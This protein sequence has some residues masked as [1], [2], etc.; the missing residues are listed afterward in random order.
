MPLPKLSPDDARA[1]RD[2]HVTFLLARLGS[3][4]A[5]AELAEG[6]RDGW[7]HVRAQRLD[8]L[9]LAKAA[10]Q[11]VE[12]LVAV[13]S[14]DALAS[15]W[16][17]LGRD[18]HARVRRDLRADGTKLGAW[19]PD[20]A[21]AA[22]DALLA[23]P[24]L[25]PPSL[26][27]TI[28]DQEGV[29]EVLRDVLYDALVEFNTT[30][31]PFFAEWGLPGLIKRFVPI[32]GGA[33]VK[34]IGALREE[35]DKRLEPEMRKFLLVFSR[36]AKKKVGAFLVAH[37]GDPSMVALRRNVAA[38]LYEQTPKALFA[39]YDDEAAAHVDR[40]AEA[41]AAAVVRSD[42]ARARL[43][44]SVAE[45]LRE[46]GE[47]TVGA[48]LDAVGATGAPDFDALAA[49]AWPSVELVLASPPFR[50]WLE[51]VTDDFYATLA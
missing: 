28:F 34:S 4:A 29:E 46:H 44:R 12:A 32:G 7:A 41:V 2:A 25:V 51:R 10:P 37:A 5:R 42:D 49:L 50:A 3:D 23:R 38:F 40:A 22:V 15:L 18:G 45:L 39:T 14:P 6:L 47:A 9:P 21:R 43:E 24:D 19:V 31:N 36:K 48:A 8:A 30:V 13:A 33:V 16:A 26:V 1:L 35:F 11:L 20:D 27:E 17:P